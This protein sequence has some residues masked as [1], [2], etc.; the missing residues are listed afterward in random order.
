V[1]RAAI[2]TIGNELVSGDTENGNASWLARRLERRGVSVGLIVAVPDKLETIARW[3][4]EAAGSFDVLLVTGGLG[5]TPDDITRE[6]VAAAFG[7]EQ[8]EVPELAADLRARFPRHPDY[9]ARFAQ[10]PKGS[11]PLQNPLGGAPGFALAN[12][13]V[14]P[15]LPAE[16]KAMF[17]VFA[18]E[19]GTEAPIH[20]WRRTYRTTEAVI[21]GLLEEA[22]RRFPGVLVGS[23]PAFEA[24]G[25]RVEVV[26]KSAEEHA[27]AA[28][29]EWL[30]A[31]LA[32]VVRD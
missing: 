26:L 25:P 32:V 7:V 30:G 20:A 16:M 27:L 14:L 12:V 6:S 4:R 21:A 3:V 10:L 28:A 1:A 13:Y 29:S 31:A 18:G 19:L 11:R 5:G 8:E 24:T 23:Y 2:L 9:A 17:D 22:V 15:G